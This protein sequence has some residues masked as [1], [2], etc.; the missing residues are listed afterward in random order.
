VR[1]ALD[2]QG[3][4]LIR[5]LLPVEGLGGLLNEILPTVSAA[6]WL[7]LGAL[8]I[9]EGSHRFGLAGD[10]ARIGASGDGEGVETVGLAARFM[11]A[12]C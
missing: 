5:N 4:L 12:M 1:D 3:Y 11:P 7:E 2:S 10:F 9:L 8:R 6:G